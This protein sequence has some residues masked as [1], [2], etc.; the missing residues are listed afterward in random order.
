M[1]FFTT[2]LNIVSV[3]VQFSMCLGRDRIHRCYFDLRGLRPILF[4]P[5]HNTGRA[6]IFLELASRLRLD[7]VSGTRI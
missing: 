4:D 6:G 7:K 5:I 2:V 1:I 3:I